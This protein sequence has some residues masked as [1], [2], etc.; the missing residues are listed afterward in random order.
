MIKTWLKSNNF[1]TGAVI[2]LIIPLPAA[3]IFALLTRL[4]Q[5]SFHIFTSVRMADM[6]LLGLAINL[7]VMR[8]YIRKLKLENTG[9]GILV[10]T[11]ALVAVFFIFLANSNFVLPF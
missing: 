2:G 1:L 5:L 7:I 3:F 8:Y 11:F 4:L 6:F 9:K 10:V